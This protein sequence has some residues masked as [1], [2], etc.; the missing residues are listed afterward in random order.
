M[1]LLNIYSEFD[2]LEIRTGVFDKNRFI[3]GITSYM[4]YF[5]INYLN[6]GQYK[7]SGEIQEIYMGDGINNKI[8][9]IKNLN[10]NSPTISIEKRLKGNLDIQDKGIRIS[11][12]KETIIDTRPEYFQGKYK[13]R[14]RTRFTPL[15]SSDKFIIE[16]TMDVIDEKYNYSI[17]LEF[18]TKPSLDLLNNSVNWLSNFVNYLKYFQEISKEYNRYFYPGLKGGIKGKDPNIPFTGEIMP[19]NLKPEMVGE[20]TNYSVINKPNGVNFILYFSKYYKKAFLLNKTDGIVFLENIEVKGD[21]ALFGEYLNK[22]FYA[23]DCLIYNGASVIGQDYP[24]RHSFLANFNNIKDIKIIPIFNTGNLYNDISS[25]FS[26]INKHWR[27]DTNDGIIF[28]PNN[29]PFNNSYTFKW[30]PEYENTIDFSIKRVGKDIYNLFAYGKNNNN[31]L[32]YGSKEYSINPNVFIKDSD[33]RDINKGEIPIDF[34]IIEFSYSDGRFYPKRIR[35]D[36]IKPNFIGVSLSI[37]QDIHQPFTADKLLKLAKRGNIR[38]IN[39]LSLPQLTERICGDLI[40][41]DTEILD[42]LPYIKRGVR[43]LNILK[44]SIKYSQEQGIDNKNI[45]LLTNYFSSSRNI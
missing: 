2:E 34:S 17:E 37:W 18:L 38:D 43:I 5:C 14:N 25:C 3:P 27:K 31:A 28:K 45:K 7:T 4:F 41:G 23:I 8:K 22:K 20:M 30:K 11:L 29:L 39:K 40:K 19:K 12:N 15:N 24:L 13:Y 32:F 26:Y 6:K 10:N 9:T 33:L 42:Q 35:I 1:D 36:K 44:E 16:L 21:N